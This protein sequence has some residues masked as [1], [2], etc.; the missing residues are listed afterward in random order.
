MSPIPI[1][2]IAAFITIIV[3]INVGDS[4]IPLLLPVSK[5]KCYLIIIL[6]FTSLWVLLIMVWIQ[7]SEI[8]YNFNNYYFK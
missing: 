1:K 3:I 6:N 4:K 7:Y 2:I 8:I 5:I